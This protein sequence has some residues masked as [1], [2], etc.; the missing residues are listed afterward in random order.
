[1]ESGIARVLAAVASQRPQG[2]WLD[3]RATIV[4]QRY[5]VEAMLAR[6][7]H[8]PVYGFT[9][10]LGQLDH[11]RISAEDQYRLLEGHLVGEP[12]KLPDPMPM[13]LLA[14]KLEQLAQGGSG[15]HFDT[16]ERLLDH[17][18]TPIKSMAGAW[19]ASY[20]SADVVPGAWW[21]HGLAG[22]GARPR[23]QAG[24]LIALISGNFVSTAFALAA[25]VQLL[26]YLSAF[27][28]YAALSADAPPVGTTAATRTWL[29]RELDAVIRRSGHAA[30]EHRATQLPVSTRDISVYVSLIARVVDELRDA[31]EFRLAACTSNPL[32]V[33]P[34]GGEP[35]AYSQA[36]FVD[37]RLSMA[38]TSAMQLVLF[39]MGG[40]QRFTQHLCDSRRQLPAGQFIAYVQPPKVA[41]ALLAQARLAHGTL[42]TSFSMAE[43]EGIED[44]GDM[45]LALAHGLRDAVG[46]AQQQLAVLAGLEGSAA[47]PAGRKH[48]LEVIA[49]R[50]CGRDEADQ[51]RAAD[52]SRVLA[53]LQAGSA[54]A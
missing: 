22:D 36:G 8:Q 32:F 52:F 49:G 24:D 30:D 48:F 34:S 11:A 42:A 33:F 21:L 4:E 3:R 2:W 20:G 19:F 10:L 35:A 50:F 13:L 45:S 25:S 18:G 7:P 43:S 14:T 23:L 17:C 53:R 54:T 37:V 46:R 39:C 47:N 31:L 27:L 29:Y 6:E 16:Y 38:L 12:D 28:G 15:I 9:T 41:Q 1:M 40:V 5:Q 51:D 44:I 26:D